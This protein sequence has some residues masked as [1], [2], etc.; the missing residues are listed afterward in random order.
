MKPCPRCGDETPA[1]LSPE[2]I[3]A[4]AAEFSVP[5]ALRAGDDLYQQRLESCG[6]CGGLREKVLCAYCG[7]FVQFR[8]RPLKSSCPNPAGDK[9]AEARQAP[10]ANTPW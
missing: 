9:W 3:A 6:K 7:C 4:L 5:A 10:T 1:V 2:R 8:A